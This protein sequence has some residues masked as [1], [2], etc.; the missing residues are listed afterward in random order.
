MLCVCVCVSVYY[1][2]RIIY[3]MR[4]LRKKEGVWNAEVLKNM[5]YAAK[6]LARSSSL[7]KCCSMFVE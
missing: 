3:F 7:I 2:V 4:G 6:A 1:V 5:T